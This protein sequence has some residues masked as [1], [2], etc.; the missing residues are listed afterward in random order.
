MHADWSGKTGWKSGAVSEEDFRIAR[1]EGLMF[2][3]PAYE[4]H[5]QALQALKTLVAGIDP[6]AVSRAFLYSLSTRR[7]DYRSALGSY[8]YAKASPA[9]SVADGQNYCDFCDW[10]AWAREP[11]EDE[12]RRGLNVLS[13][14]RQKWGG[15]RH[16]QLN[17]ARF[18]LEQFLLLPEVTPSGADHDIFDRILACAERLEAHEKAGKLADLILREKIF[19]TNR[20]ELS[21]LL[22]ELGVCGILARQEYPSYA[23]RFVDIYGRAPAEHKNDF[24]Y[25]VNRWRGKD[26]VNRQKL[27]ELFRF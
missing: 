4:T 13:F 5:D 27:Q 6:E 18:D 7:L 21:V 17:Y 8:Y 1:A 19:K 10:T 25:P 26:G 16:T 3:Y 24:A 2:D 22:N 12:K 9:H 15:V 20:A 23:D 11:D 14:E